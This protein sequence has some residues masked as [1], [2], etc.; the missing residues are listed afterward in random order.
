MHRVAKFGLGNL[1]TSLS[2]LITAWQIFAAI[3]NGILRGGG[4]ILPRHTLMFTLF[5]LW[6]LIFHLVINKCIYMIVRWFSTVGNRAFAVAAARVWNDLPRHV[7]SLFTVAVSF[8]QLSEDSSF[9]PFLSRLSVVPAK[10]LVSLSDVLIAF[11]IYE[12]THNWEG[13]CVFC[14]GLSRLLEYSS[15]TWVVNYRSNFCFS[16]THYFLLPVVNFY[17]RLQFSQ[18][19]DDFFWNLRKQG[20]SRFHLQLWSVMADRKCTHAHWRQCEMSQYADPPPLFRHWQ[21]VLKYFRY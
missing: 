8:Q 5:E 15:N 14:I 20:A 4:H 1:A 11:V 17:F 21:L 12:L 18:S 16:S 7:T 10:W 6:S 3:I 13:A 2:N 19:I 9:Q